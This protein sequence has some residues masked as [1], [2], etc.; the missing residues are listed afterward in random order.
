VKVSGGNIDPDKFSKKPVPE[1]LRERPFWLRPRCSVGQ[2]I[3]FCGLPLSAEDRRQTPIACPTTAALST[4][5]M[6][7]QLCAD[8]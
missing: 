7:R 5:N 8:V 2:A 3:A 6:S 1:G 4:A